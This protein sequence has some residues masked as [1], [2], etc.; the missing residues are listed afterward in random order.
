MLG[1][2]S[3][4]SSTG[5]AQPRHRN[6]GDMLVRLE[7][8]HPSGPRAPRRVWCV[9]TRSLGTLGVSDSFPQPWKCR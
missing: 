9:G 2:S 5:Q 1:P 4:P 7:L 6:E 8:R 3:S